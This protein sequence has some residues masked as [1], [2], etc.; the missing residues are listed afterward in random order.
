M[1]IT[2]EALDNYETVS[3]GQS[4]LVFCIL[5]KNCL[6]RSNSKQRKAHCTNR[7]G[8]NHLNKVIKTLKITHLF[9]LNRV[10]CAFLG[11]GD[12]PTHIIPIA[13]DPTTYNR[14]VPELPHK[15]QTKKGEIK[16]LSFNIDRGDVSKVSSNRSPL[17]Y[18]TK[19]A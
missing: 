15:I 9:V 11:S 7:K 3:R 4:T 12:E 18:L 6:L 2:E 5:V 1:D 16:Y 8:N 17:N 14:P 19:I 10:F 13:L